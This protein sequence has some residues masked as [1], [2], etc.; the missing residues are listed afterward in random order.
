MGLAKATLPFGDELMLQRVVR[1]LG[2]EVL[3]IAVVAAGGQA[4]PTLPAE[5]IVARDE[6]EGGVP[7]E[8]LLAGLTVLA[9]HCDAAYAT[10]C[11]VPLLVAAFVRQMISRLGDHEIV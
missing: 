4:L 2:Q 1:L 8:G 10:S 9:P 7:L 3:P 5:V 6:R 11:D